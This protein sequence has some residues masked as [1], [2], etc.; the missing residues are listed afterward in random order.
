MPRSTRFPTLQAPLGVYLLTADQPIPDGNARSI[1]GDLLEALLRT[2]R[3]AS[4]MTKMA[5]SDHVSHERRTVSV[6]ARS[7]PVSNTTATTMASPD[8][9]ETSPLHAS[10]RTSHLHDDPRY[11]GRHQPKSCVRA[12]S[13]SPSGKA[14]RS[15]TSTAVARKVR[16]ACSQPR[17]STTCRLTKLRLV[18][19][20]VDEDLEA[21]FRKGSK[22]GSPVDRMVRRLKESLSLSTI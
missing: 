2:C 10:A 14:F 18:L 15:T 22:A 1:G 19:Y 6:T 16:R 5:I 7:S 20:Q 4:P 21:S 13:T 3:I 8:P 9:A 17:N 11:Y 12:L